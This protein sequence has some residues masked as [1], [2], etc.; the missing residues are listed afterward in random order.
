MIGNIVDPEFETQLKE[1]P[2]LVFEAAAQPGY[3]NDSRVH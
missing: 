2:Y 1:G 3:K